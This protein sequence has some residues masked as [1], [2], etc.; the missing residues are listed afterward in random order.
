V[1]TLVLIFCAPQSLFGY[2]R[3]KWPTR[4]SYMI[5]PSTSKANPSN[6]GR[7]KQPGNRTEHFAKRYAT[8]VY[9]NDAIGRWYHF[10]T[11][12]GIKSEE[13]SRILCWSS[14][15]TKH[16]DGFISLDI[17]VILMLL[18]IRHIS[19]DISV[20][21][22]LL[23]FLITKLY[24]ALLALW[25]SRRISSQMIQYNADVSLEPLLVYV[26]QGETAL[27]PYKDS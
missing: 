8:K 3:S 14:L 12:A 19:L 13:C 1:S 22:I 17:S 6:A 9:L 11:E 18:Y 20:M 24:C 7:Q 21:L 5:E 10:K 23:Y 26:Q 25:K 16:Q 4:K 15:Y 27:Q 2:A